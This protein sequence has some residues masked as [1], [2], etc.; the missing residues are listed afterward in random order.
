MTDEKGEICL[1]GEAYDLYFN[2]VYHVQE[3]EPPKGYGGISFDYKVTLTSDMSRVDYGHFIYYYAD[4]MQIKNVPL[5]GL[6]VEKQVESDELS[7]KEQYYQFRISI[8]KEDGTVDT[9]YNEKNGDDQFINGVLEFE[10]KDK[11]QKMFRG[12]QQGTSIRSK[13]QTQ[14]ALPYL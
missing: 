4:S 11:E 2:E 8:L 7:D 6:V 3:I 5:E 14:R 13:R 1:D 12:L 10:L 9:E